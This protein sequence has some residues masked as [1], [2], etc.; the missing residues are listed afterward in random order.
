[1]KKY[2]TI[3]VTLI[4]LL[5]FCTSPTSTGNTESSKQL[6]TKKV[7]Y[8]SNAIQ[9]S[10]IYEYDWRNRLIR[11][12]C[13]DTSHLIYKFN[14]EYNP[15]GTVSQAKLLFGGGDTSTISY[16]YDLNDSLEKW[17][18]TRSDTIA[19]DS[20]VYL[21]NVENKT[22]ELRMYFAGQFAQYIIYVYGTLG[23]LASDTL[24]PVQDSH[25]YYDTYE[26]DSNQRLIKENH[27]EGNAIM[28]DYLTF[29]YNGYGNLSRVNRLFPSGDP[30]GY[31]IYYYK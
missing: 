25:V 27:F 21:R 9:D 31:T 13:Y 22:I 29:E 19:V 16:F 17:I 3:S 10:T 11:E 18:Q 30:I 8:L 24:H 1:M 15:N 14:Y 6:L 20:G 26:Y 23:L 4:P 2:L 7:V 12:S 5:F 28:R